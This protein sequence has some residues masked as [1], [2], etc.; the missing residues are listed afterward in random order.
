MSN[1]SKTGVTAH[2]SQ[3]AGSRNGEP[4]LSDRVRSLRLGDRPASGSARGGVLPW[5]ICALLLLTTLAFG[6]RTYRMT[7]ATDATTEA[8]A[9]GADRTTP[10]TVAAT[11]AAATGDVVLESKGYVIPVHT[12]QV[13]PKVGGL[14]VWLHPRFEEGA[15]FKEGDEL[16]RLED[17]DYKADRDRSQANLAA[18]EQRLAELKNGNRPEE[19]TQAKEELAEFEAQLRQLRLDLERS[20]RLT[21]N[22]ALAQRD[23]EQAKYG[24]EAMERKV[25][26]LRTA[27]DLMVKGPRDERIKAAAAD[28]AQCKADLVRAQ[29][30]LDNCR[31]VAPVTGTVLTKKAE[32][33]NLVN[34]SAFSNGLSA[35]LCD[36]ADL[37][38]LEVEL[39]IQE[40]DIAKVIVGQPCLALPEAFQNHEP[41]RKLYPNG[42]T[43]KVS[44]MMPIADR[45]QSAIPVRVK[46][47]VP[48]GE[49]GVYLKPDMGVIVSFRKME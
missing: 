24:Y 13:S 47:N 8:P 43:G 32:R 48:R 37:A 18:A 38:D 40:R 35:S 25:A 39:K 10:A 29:W 26:R 23:F 3:S 7:P 45:A 41:F 17:V 28:V 42:Y 21:G 31:I 20:Q 14:L 33:G 9:N 5:F 44:R 22:N 27:Y 19:I 4:S 46:L 16:A 15:I 36:M 30:R 12:V 6:Y 49:E 1:I 11:T 2:E 34:P